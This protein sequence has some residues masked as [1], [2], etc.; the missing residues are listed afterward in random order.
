MC[1]FHLH[2]NSEQVHS[3]GNAELRNVAQLENEMGPGA[4]S[5]VS[6]GMDGRCSLNKGANSL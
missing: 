6:R 5:V 3:K 2:V 1:G 4:N